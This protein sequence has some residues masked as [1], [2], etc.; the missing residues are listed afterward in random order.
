[1]L[2]NLINGFIL[3]SLFSVFVNDFFIK[4]MDLQ[5]V[6]VGALW[7][8]SMQLVIRELG[9][10]L[11]KRDKESVLEIRTLE[12]SIDNKVIAEEQ[13]KLVS[14]NS[15]LSIESDRTSEEDRSDL[16]EPCSSPYFESHSYLNRKKSLLNLIKE[17][18]GYESTMEVLSEIPDYLKMDS[19]FL[20]EIIVSMHEKFE[21]LPLHEIK[22]QVLAQI[23][24]EL[25][26]E[27]EQEP[28]YFSCQLQEL[29]NLMIESLKKQLLFKN[30]DFNKVFSKT[31]QLA[32]GFE[33]Y[34][35]ENAPFLREVDS[36]L[37][38]RGNVLSGSFVDRVCLDLESHLVQRE[39]LLALDAVLSSSNQK[40]L[41]VNFFIED[42]KELTKEMEFRLN[43]LITKAICQLGLGSHG[44]V[45]RE[46]LR[47]NDY[48]LTKVIR[49]IADLPEDF[50]VGVSRLDQLRNHVAKMPDLEQDDSW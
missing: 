47:N 39:V 25:S 35:L 28:S 42:K 48:F 44:M 45:L 9:Q 19:N 41:W 23:S 33:E 36:L 50:D 15:L 21:V 38:A 17:A 14:S 7:I 20:S 37:S 40:V 1:M 31:L 27:I 10:F 22:S 3:N 46:E 34:L 8:G 18:H 16:S 12:T 13:E 4:N 11:A 24:F 43:T 30:P 32:E 49:K 2:V 6:A 26:K 29:K 5:K